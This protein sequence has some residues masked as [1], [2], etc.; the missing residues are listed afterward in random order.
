MEPQPLSQPMNCEGAQKATVIGV[1]EWTMMV[2]LG[3]VEPEVAETPSALTEAKSPALREHRAGQQ[4]EKHLDAKF[5][6][7]EN[8]SD[9]I[10]LGRPELQALGLFLEQVG[11][12]GRLWVQFTAL[13]A[14]LPVIMPGNGKPRVFKVDEPKVLRGPDVQEIPIVM[15]ESDYRYYVH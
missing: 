14:R 4:K 5:F 13:N 6:L 3:V 11:D 1:V 9:P 8:L 15:S 12:D 7:M 2:R 10:I